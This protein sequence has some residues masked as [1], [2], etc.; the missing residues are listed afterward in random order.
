[1]TEEEAQAI[2]QTRLDAARL[3]TDEEGG[4]ALKGEQQQEEE[5]VPT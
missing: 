4:G 2:M 1:M 3:A 5:Q